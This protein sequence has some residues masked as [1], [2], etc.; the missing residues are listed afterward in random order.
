MFFGNM[1]QLNESICD[2]LSSQ[3]DGED[4]NKDK[5]QPWI[6]IMDFSLVLGIDSSAAQAITKLNKMMRKKFGVHL[7]IF[8]TGSSDGFP[9]DYSLSEELIN[10]MGDMQ[11]SQNDRNNFSGD[12]S[13]EQTALLARKTISRGYTGSQ[14]C[15]TLDLA[16][17]M[18]EDAL[19]F[20]KDPSLLEDELDMTQH[21]VLPA[22]MEKSSGIRH[23]RNMCSQEVEEVQ[24]EILFSRF[25]RQVYRK[26]DTLWT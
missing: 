11:L 8:V 17:V 23:L 22:S 4:Q 20:K 26:G 12:Y 3:K 5:I 9:C 24:L 1:A 13:N 21:D 25:H 19:I 7:C 10:V 6:V 16:L 2:V 15:Q 14:V 18:S